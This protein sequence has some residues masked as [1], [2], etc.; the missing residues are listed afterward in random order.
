MSHYAWPISLNYMKLDFI[1]GK[2]FCFVKDPVKRIRQG[3]DWEKIFAKDASD[4][5][6]LTKIY[7]E[8]LKLSEKKTNHPNKLSVLK[9]TKD[10]NRHL[11]KD[12]QMENKPRKNTLYQ[13][14]RE[15]QI[16]T[17]FHYTPIRMAKSQSGTV[18]HSCNPSTLGGRSRWITQVRSSRP[19]WS[20]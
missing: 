3:T 9:W 12:L 8:L 5:G 17:R 10:L 11:T 19:A 6:L 15:L 4:K 13:V 14:I 18:A 20:T 16:K 2:K 1:K 7:K